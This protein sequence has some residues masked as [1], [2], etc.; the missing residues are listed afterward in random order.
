M[1]T[2]AGTGASGLKDGPAARAQFAEPG[3]L[4]IAD[5][6]LYV[7][8]TN[9]HAIRTIDLATND[10]RTLPLRSL[11]PPLAYSYLRGGRRLGSRIRDQGSGIR[12]RESGIRDQS[13]WESGSPQAQSP[14]P[15][16]K[17][18]APSPKPQDSSLEPGHRRRAH[19]VP[20][21]QGDE[22]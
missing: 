20:G 6:V 13:G 3:G 8:D 11:T 22:R 10:V 5:G 12:D 2:L 4:S 21:S 18:Q 1:K 17:P 15:S 9:N 16:P 19:A 14:A 7:A